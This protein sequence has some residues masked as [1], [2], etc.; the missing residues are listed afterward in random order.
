MFRI[1]ASSVLRSV[2]FVVLSISFLLLP[3]PFLAQSLCEALSAN[4]LVAH[5][6]TIKWQQEATVGLSGVPV[7]VL[8][9]LVMECRHRRHALF[10]ALAVSWFTGTAT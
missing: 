9:S 5:F 1:R 8:I 6:I 4:S 2:V 10:T 3:Y 7:R